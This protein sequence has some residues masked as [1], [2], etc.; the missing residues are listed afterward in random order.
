MLVPSQLSP[1]N[2]HQPFCFHKLYKCKWHMT[3]LEI[4]SPS[5]KLIDLCYISLCWILWET[6]RPWLLVT[7]LVFIYDFARMD[8]NCPFYWSKKKIHLLSESQ[9][10]LCHWPNASQ[11]GRQLA[12]LFLALKTRTPMESLFSNFA[13]HWVFSFLILIRLLPELSFVSWYLCAF[14][15]PTIYLLP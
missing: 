1:Q 13:T 7:V 6:G 3:S 12:F 10:S 2:L 5:Y 4:M 15:L 11:S 8:H 14:V 9:I